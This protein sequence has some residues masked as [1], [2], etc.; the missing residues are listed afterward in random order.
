MPG[1]HGGEVARHL[2]T[3]PTLKDAWVIATSAN[4]RHDSR[5]QSYAGYFHDHLVKPYNLDHLERLLATCAASTA[6]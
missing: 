1:M 2:K 5:L 6:E 4:E 3:D